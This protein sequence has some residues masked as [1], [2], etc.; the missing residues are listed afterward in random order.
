MGRVAWLLLWAAQVTKMKLAQKQAEGIAEAR[1]GQRGPAGLGAGVQASVWGSG[2][3]GVACALAAL[4]TDSF[5]L[6]QVGFV[7]SFASKLSDTVSSEVGKA[8]GRT[9]YLVT[10]FQLVPRGTEGAVSAEGTAAGVLAA[11]LIAGLA[12]G[13]GQVSWEGC[14]IVAAAAVVANLFESYL[15]AVVQ[16]RVVWLTNDLVNMIQIS[17][18]AGLALAAAAVLRA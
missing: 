1:S 16:G 3:A 11:L 12:W 10:T 18:A 14:L 2:I 17:V 6:W 15:G 13:L 4:A 7:A 5:P 8:Y 9:T